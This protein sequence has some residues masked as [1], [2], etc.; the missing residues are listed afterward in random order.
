M[1]EERTPPAGRS[2]P[3]DATSRG[4]QPENDS[5]AEGR[6]EA[7][8]RKADQVSCLAEEACHGREQERIAAAEETRQHQEELRQAAETARAAGEEARL[9]AESARRAAVNSLRATAESLQ[10]SLD[11]MT[12]VEEM[13]RALADL[14]D[15]TK[16][17]SN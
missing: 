4:E 10:I 16:L 7:A 6:R 11:R 1:A 5:G 15:S 17:D 12:A 14:R 9:Q 13:R 3:A 8:T 2:L